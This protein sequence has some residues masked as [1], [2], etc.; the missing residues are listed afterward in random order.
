MKAF[1]LILV[2]LL[3]V[4]L[5]SGQ[6]QS[7]I[8]S[9][10]K[11]LTDFFAQHPYDQLIVTTDKT[12]YHPGEKIWFRCIVTDENDQ[13]SSNSQELFVRLYNAE[14]KSESQQL[15]KLVHGFA[16][17]DLNLSKELKPGLYFLCAYTVAINDPARVSITK[18]KIDP[19]YSNQW[20]AEVAFQDSISSA[21]I[22][23]EALIH[24]KELSG[25]IQKNTSFHYQLL[26]GVEIVEKGK[27]KSD[28]TGKVSIPFTL[29]AKSNGALFYLR[30]NDNREEWEQKTYIPSDLDSIVVSFFP[31][32]GNLIAGIASKIGLTAF[33]KWGIPVQLEGSIQN[34][35]GEIITQVKTFT[36]G[37]GLFSLLPQENQRYQLILNGIKGEKHHF[38]LPVALAS[39]LALSVVKSDSEFIT[40]NLQLSDQKKH[41]LSVSISKGSNIYWA[42]DIQ[43]EKSSRIRIPVQ[44]LPKGIN[45]LSVFSSDGK[46][47]ADRLLYVG[48]KEAFKITILPEKERLTPGEETSIKFLLTDENNQPLSGKFSVSITDKNR[49][50]F[51]QPALNETLQATKDLETPF[52]II[53]KSLNGR[54][55]STTLTDIYLIANSLKWTNWKIINANTSE[56][57]TKSAGLSANSLD[58]NFDF[59]LSSFIKETATKWLLTFKPETADS[60]YFANNPEIFPKAPK[61]FK[62]NTISLD[63]QRKMLESA[64]SLLDVIKSIKPFKI[65]NNQIVFIGSENSFNYQGGALIVLDGQQ[66]GTDVS[67]LSSISPVEVDHINVSTNP[68][69]IQRYT[70][71]NSV[72]IIEI[73]QKRA[74]VKVEESNSEPTEKYDRGY[75]VPTIFPMAPGNSKHDN[76]TTLVW[77]PELMT[78]Q[79]GQAEVVVKAGAI[80]TD[81]VIKVECISANG[82]IGMGQSI[83][84]INK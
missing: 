74:V 44:D 4:Q 39:G 6:N 41:D 32:G 31:E 29:P 75:R 53:S 30:L 58:K 55:T 22:K 79:N 61:I 59:Q 70:G 15:F 16:A 49:L 18:L 3:S 66:M 52:S 84:P 63:N 76:R 27:A 11:K 82:K 46:L 56:Q 38:E 73:F 37:L 21:G 12:N 80:A 26:N 24:L 50:K 65:T 19:E 51:P 69:D 64:T 45:L 34:Q 81:F 60:I 20:I 57:I 67:A 43:V 48:K 14:G 68:M 72:G 28:K 77:I 33:N 25:A 83:L 47:L 35:Q 78:N 40:A 23:N 62:A 36:A 1:S 71:L 8:P 54:L 13:V 10:S 2:F 9:I 7:P 5:L 42:A 17:C